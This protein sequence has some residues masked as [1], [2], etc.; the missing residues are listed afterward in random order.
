MSSLLKNTPKKIEEFVVSGASKRGWT[1]WTTA[2]V[3]DRVIAIVPIVIDMLNIIPSF[4]HHW[5]AYGKWAA[6]VGNYEG[7]GIME[8]QNSEEYQRLAEL[9]EPF[10]FRKKLT[11]PKLLLNA[12]GDQFF[13]PDSWQ[14]YWKELL[15]EKHVR[16]VPNSEHSMRETDASESLMSFYQMVIANNPRPNFNWKL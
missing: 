4:N 3:D 12:T 5:R 16:Y 13:L 15:G 10:N 2:I 6:A 8:W 1:T 9:T 11:L 14:F 7:E